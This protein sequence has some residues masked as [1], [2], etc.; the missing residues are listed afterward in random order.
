MKLALLFPG[1]G[2]QFA[3]MGR[4]LYE[5]FEEVRG[6]FAEASDL[7]GEDVWSWCS[8]EE[9][10][11]QTQYVQPAMVALG[12]AL[13]DVLTVRYG[14]KP[15]ASAGLSLGEYAALHAGGVLGAAQAV[16]LVAKRGK[17]MQHVTGGAMAA[18]LGMERA[19]V[20]EA[21]EHAR[22]EGKSVWPCNYNCPGQIVISGASEGVD[23]AAT[24]LKEMGARRV[25]P[26][27]VSGPFHTPLMAPA[28]D[29]FAPVLAEASLAPAGFPVYS[30]VTA[31]PHGDPQAMR[32]LLHRQIT[33]PVRWEDTLQTMAA[34]GVDTFLELGPGKTVSGFVK[35]TLD[36][37]TI[38]N[39]EDLDSLCAVLQ[40]LE[41][42]A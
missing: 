13:A 33:S 24:I 20:E 18:V 5:Q 41:V 10:L 27:N 34:A 15:K 12:A 23:A 35:K 26:L 2:A 8:D 31:Q 4:S 39:V 7:V 3:G 6:V 25:L 22:A 36:G 30:N 32:E 42:P 40:K 16:A 37:V 28:A 38:L 9:K 17:L 19:Q 14:I 11:K 29:A 21:C 1:Q